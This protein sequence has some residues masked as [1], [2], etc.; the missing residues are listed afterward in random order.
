M[1]KEDVM[2]KISDLFDELDKVDQ[3]TMVKELILNNAI[4]VY[5]VGEIDSDD[6]FVWTHYQAM[7]IEFSEEAA[8]QQ[9]Y[10]RGC[11]AT[12]VELVYNL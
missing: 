4:P 3:A 9:A 1:K 6:P 7:G 12:L 11:E 10:K 5:V 8:R 2:E